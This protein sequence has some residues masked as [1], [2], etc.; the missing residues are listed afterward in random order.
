MQLRQHVEKVEGQEIKQPR[1]LD[2]FGGIARELGIRV[3]EH[4]LHRG[5]E[6]RAEIAALPRLCDRVRVER[7][8]QPSRQPRP[9]VANR[10]LLDKTVVDNAF[11]RWLA[12]VV[13]AAVP[14]EC[15][16]VLRRLR[17]APREEHW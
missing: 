1:P 11:A 17:K 9:D 5:D 6:R 2:G 13:D 15:L 4:A 14:V 8:E 12:I 16:G 7:V 10:L 3:G